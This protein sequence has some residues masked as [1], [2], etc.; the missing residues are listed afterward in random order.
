MKRKEILIPLRNAAIVLLCAAAIL[1]SAEA[2]LAL[3]EK[4]P[5]TNDADVETAEWMRLE[6]SRIESILTAEDEAKDIRVLTGRDPSEFQKANYPLIDDMPASADYENAVNIVMLG[7]SFLWGDGSVNR[8]ELCWRQAEQILRGMGYNCRVYAVAMR[9]ATAYEELD[10]LK[11]G[12]IDDLQPDIVIFGYVY[13]DMLI[14]GDDYEEKAGDSVRENM[15]FL[16]PAETVFP[17]I[18]EKLADYIAAKTIY[19]K[20]YGDQYG[21]TNVAV[22]EGERLAYYRTHFADALDRLSR[23]R[24]LPAAVMTLP[25]T[26]GSTALKE[27]YR[28]LK[29]VF[30][31]TCVRFYDSTNAFA[32]YAVPKYADNIYVNPKNRHPGSATNRFYAEYICGFL[33]K[34]FSEL[35]GERSAYSLNGS[36]VLINENTPADIDLQKRSADADGATYT[37][38]YPDITAPHYYYQLEIDPYCLHLPDGTDYVKLCFEN[39]VDIESVSL[40]GNGLRAAALYGT[41]IDKELRYDNN[42]AYPF[43]ESEGLWLPENGKA[44]ASLCVH[45]EFTDNSDRT[46]TITIKGRTIP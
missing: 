19:S 12:V 33:Q 36:S 41:V 10:W 26:P 7:D 13:N 34:D 37:F 45:A 4:T 21:G 17:R 5:G 11:N 3:L 9:G 24:N 46:L 1:F 2:V 40:N 15:K 39:P 29:D 14:R 35:L 18:C 32:R 42:T 38:T 27:L 31:N 44:V 22:P 30:K 25:N 16:T 20:K 8:N 23:E 43:H 6:K 28:P